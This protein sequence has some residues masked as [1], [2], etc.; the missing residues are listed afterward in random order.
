VVAGATKLRTDPGTPIHTMKLHNLFSKIRLANLFVP[1]FLALGAPAVFAQAPT[2]TPREEK[3]LNGL[4]LIMSDAPASDKVTLKV[5][6]HAGSAFD[7]QG[8]EG[9]MKLL[10]ANIF[11]NPEAKE[12]FAEEL[13]GS[14]EILSNY[15]YIQINASSKPEGFLSM[16]EAV[17]NATVNVDINKEMTARLKTQQLKVIETLMADPAY[18]ADQA[19]AARLFGT[20]PYGRPA[21]GTAASVATIDFADLLSAKQR[22]FTSDNA[23]VLIAG[24]IDKDQAYR[25]VRRYFGAWIKS[26]KRVPWTF[27]QPDAPPTGVQIVTSPITDRFEVRVATRGTSRGSNDLAAFRVAAAVIENRLKAQLP[28]GGNGS[29]MVESRDHVLPGAVV[30]KFSG[31]TEA[32]NPKIDANDVVTRALSTPVTDAEFQAAK[33]KAFSELLE[34]NV[35]DRW[36]DVDTYKT[37]LPSA[38]QARVAS[39]SLGNV[40]DVISRLKGQPKAAVIVSANKPS[41]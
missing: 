25:A 29:I 27:K 13:G 12:Y 30:I 33:P 36:L 40:Q 18:V 7:P 2:T 15:D 35:Y 31:T 26:D 28:T 38:F 17:A 11:P 14:L 32:G 21:D 34:Y 8:K 1:V 37:E 5:R 24:K 19:A 39:V 16:L 23:T 20:F 4:K 3:L 22:F 10:A 9:L 6:I 41:E